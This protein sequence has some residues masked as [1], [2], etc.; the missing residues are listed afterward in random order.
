V[1]QG[2]VTGDFVAYDAANGKKLWSQNV[3]SGVAA[4]PVTYE[5]GGD[6]YVTVATGW[7]SVFALTAGFWFDRAVPPAVGKVVT[8]KLGG[9]G[10]IPDP[11]L[12]AIEATP[13]APA[14]GDAAMVQA[15]LTQYS[16]NCAV[17]HG[18]LAISSG[19]LPDLRWSQISADK[20]SWNEVVLNGAL[21]NNGMV[22]FNRQLTQ[23]EA[24]A[25]RAYVLHQANKPMS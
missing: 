8:F 10:T 24:E 15:G 14:F 6:Q 20:A 16:R 12:P 23:Q 3:K 18:P 21:A 4:P 2:T 19:V 1:F 22:A 25:I 9:K 13:K 7:G 5:I 17:C 11:D